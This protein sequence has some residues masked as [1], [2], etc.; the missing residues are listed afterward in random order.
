ME[1]LKEKFEALAH[2]IQSSGKPAAAWFP[3]FTPVTL[4]NAENWWEA[5]AVCEY[6]LDTH[7][8]EA[9]TA[10]FFELIFSAYDCNVE[11]DLNEEEYAYWWE[12]VISVCDRVAVF[13]GAGWSQKGAQYSEARYGKRDLSLLFPCYEK[14]AE[15]GS[16]EAEA[17]V[18]LQLYPHPKLCYGENITGLMPSSTPAVKRKP[19]LCE[20]SCLTNFPKAIACVPMY[21]PRWATHL[22]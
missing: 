15:M 6:A 21:M 9:L 16:P 4:L 18:D 17:T 20:K 22:I 19:C 2:R 13:N 10:G 7:E 5:L 8:D 3:Q 12:K 11:V 14:A 1:T